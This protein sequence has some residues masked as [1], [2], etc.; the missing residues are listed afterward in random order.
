[1]PS[2]S[3]EKWSVKMTESVIKKFPYLNE[4]WSYDYGV[5]FKGIE[6]VWLQESNIGYF[7]YIR[8]NIDYFVTDNGSIRFYRPEEYNID[9]INNGKTLLFLYRETGEEKYKKA[10]ELLREQ[11]KKHPRT[12]A[13]GFWHK[14]I[15]PHQ[16]WLDGL[17]MGIPFYAEFGKIM[18]EKEIFDDAARQLI[19][20]DEKARDKKT[21]LHFHGWDES[22]EQNWAN[23]DTGCSMS[24]WSRAQGWYA[25][26]LVDSLDYFPEGHKD[27]ITIIEILNH[28]VTA[29]AKIQ[30]EKTGVWNQVLDTKAENGNYPEAS[31]SAMFVYTIAKSIRMGYI[32]PD[33]LPVIQKGYEGILKYFLSEDN[34]GLLI[35]KNTVYTAGLGNLGD[36][37]YR[38][39]SFDYYVSCP[40]QDDNLI[41]I[42]AFIMASIEMEQ[43]EN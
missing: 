21:G 35:F 10:A 6:H 28:L 29:L 38:D 41:G 42:G 22:R 36:S 19:L 32:A 27:R 12:E 11:L 14:K 5:L 33:L 3:T 34:S 40:V 13:G 43:K 25:M 30:D 37:P 39:G 15:Y 17:Y 9:H 2:R 1:M 8:E 26:A 31:A 16:M 20:I 4:K 18:G 7:N 24:F 23:Q